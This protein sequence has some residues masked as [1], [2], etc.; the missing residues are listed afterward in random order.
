MHISH[1]IIHFITGEKRKFVSN[2]II[3][4]ISIAVNELN[5][6][7]R[8]VSQEGSC[9]PKLKVIP[10]PHNPM[11][12]FSPHCTALHRCSDDTGCCHSD[13]STCQPRQIKHVTLPFWV[14]VNGQSRATK[15]LVK[16]ENT[17]LMRRIDLPDQPHDSFHFI[18]V[19]ALFR[20]PQE[21]LDKLKL[22]DWLL[23]TIPNADVYR[24]ACWLQIVK[25]IELRAHHCQTMS[26]SVGSAVIKIQY[27]E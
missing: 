19:I 24:R 20:C 2:N 21:V 7:I 4:W 10:I 5:A 8:R 9:R 3:T 13:S 15:F 27:V 16:L 26:Q 12:T 6:H 14:S 22:N 25:R 17:K 18:S 1:T 11:K 23:K